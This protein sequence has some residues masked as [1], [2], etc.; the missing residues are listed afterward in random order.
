MW[1]FPGIGQTHPGISI[2]VAS[3]LQP[4]LIINI[5][6]N[7]WVSNFPCKQPM[8]SLWTRCYLHPNRVTFNP[9][10]T[11]M[12]HLCCQKRVWLLSLSPATLFHPFPYNQHC[13]DAV[14]HQLKPSS[15]AVCALLAEVPEPAHRGVEHTA[16]PVQRQQLE[17]EVSVD[18]GKGSGATDF[19]S[20]A[21]SS[22]LNHPLPAQSLHLKAAFCTNP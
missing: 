11:M 6:N 8:Y 13:S 21:R 15:S 9:K 2:C 7:D 18:K 10:S 20:S 22:R 16:V 14:S 19:S 4:F 12:K 5:G 3:D 17:P 1:I